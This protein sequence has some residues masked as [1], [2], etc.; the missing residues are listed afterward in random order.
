MVAF[1]QPSPP[2]RAGLYGLSRT[3]LSPFTEELA[4]WKQ[5][6]DEWEHGVS[7]YNSKNNN[8]KQGAGASLKLCV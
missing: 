7:T 8:N 2:L 6:L 3:D 4:E 5:E 1:F